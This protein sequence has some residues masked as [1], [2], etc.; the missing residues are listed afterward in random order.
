LK[1]QHTEIQLKRPQPV[2]KAASRC[3]AA[4]FSVYDLS[5]AVSPA[6]KD[7]VV[8]LLSFKRTLQNTV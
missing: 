5:P 7:E 4:S 8:K 3:P 2:E 6:S 1:S